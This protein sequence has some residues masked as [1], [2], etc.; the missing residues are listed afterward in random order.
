M[1]NP[2]KMDDYSEEAYGRPD[3]DEN[4][5]EGTQKIVKEFVD[6]ATTHGIPRVLNA[7]RPWHS[8]LFWCVVTLILAG[9]FL[10]Q[11]SMLVF[12]FINRPTTT[13]ISIIT[14]SKL[15]FPAVT[16]CNL[17]MLRRSMLKGTRFEKL[18]A[19][20]QDHAVSGIGLEDSDYSWFFSEPSSLGG[21][22]TDGETS[23]VDTT[24]PPNR[25]RRALN[26]ESSY[27][28]DDE[29]DY[30][31]IEDIKDP[32]DW[33]ALY[34]HSKASDYTNF[35]NYVKPTR[36]EM[37]MLGHQAKDFILQCTFDTEAC[38]YKN[39]T[40][41][42]NAEYGNCFVFNNAHKLKRKKRTP[43][44]RTGSQYGLQLTL[45][46]EQPEYIGVLS[47]DSGVKVAIN[48]P[49][50]YAFPEDDGIEAAPGIKTSIGIKKTSISRLPKPYGDCMRKHTSYYDPEKYDF[51]QR[52][53]LK[54]CLQK[55]LQ[56]ECSCV[57]D[58]LITGS[59]CQVTNREQGNC[60]NRVFSDFI[61]NR[62]NCNCSNACSESVFNPRI[63]ISRWPATRYEAH[64]YDRLAMINKKAARILTNVAQSRNNLVRL[65]VFYEE[66]N[67]ENVVES[68]LI[69]VE[70]LFGSL[71]GLLGLYI[72]MSFISATE[73]LVFIYELLRSSCS[74]R[75]N[76]SKHTKVSGP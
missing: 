47:P 34:N 28:S 48:D 4:P 70:S 20:D 5:K 18:A 12:S 9:V 41:I 67:F 60:R 29:Y 3:Y 31:D 39:F 72:G 15:E 43:T 21:E 30:T 42:Q 22:T 61:R 54:L 57:T 33:E 11:G 69:T 46:L 17:N 58:I 13:K 73:I 35:K 36:E 26:A 65:S 50:I 49:R 10:Y 32:N 71:G 24:F 68:P 2:E 55:T 45:M 25:G 19:L 40:V 76:S 8:R 6:N 1:T 74:R 27:Y 16:I 62:L 44:S 52:S 14:K 56:S 63:A 66:L 38:S 59:M 51:S 23:E 75:G 53:C 7:S 37:R 64:L